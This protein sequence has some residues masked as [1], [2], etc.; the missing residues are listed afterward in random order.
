RP[1]KAAI[2]ERKQTFE[3]FLEE[4][5]QLEEQRLEQTQK[6]QEAK[7][8][9]IHKPVIKRPFLKRGEGLTRFTNAKSKPHKPGENTPELQQRASDDRIV[10]RAGRAQIQ[11]KTLPLGKEQVSESPFALRKKSTCPGK[12]KRCPVRK[13]L[14]L[15]NHSGRD[16][17]P[18]QKS[19]RPRKDHEGQM[20][21]PFPSEKKHNVAKKENLA[22]FT[23]SNTGKIENKFLGTEKPQLSREMA[24]ASSDAKC[25]AGHSG[26]DPEV[27]FEVSFQN[28]LESWEKE[29]EKENLELDEFLFLEQAADEMSFSSNSSFVQRILAQDQQKLNGRRMSSTP[30]K[31]KEQP[32]LPV[33]LLNKKNKKATCW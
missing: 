3:E 17:L 19:V 32:E 15:R 22:E 31:G 12:T 25:P 7:G 9:A 14:V 26:K 20:R 11:R 33:E 2:Q 23:K 27:S 6:A 10:I 4:Q 30:I 18:S 28:K 16:V 1:I 24:D 5:I 21:D 8:P 13:T 29:K